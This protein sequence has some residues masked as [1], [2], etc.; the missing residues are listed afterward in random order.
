MPSPRKLRADTRT[1]VPEVS[2]LVRA[3]A[4]AEGESFSLEEAAALL[5][6][7]SDQLVTHIRD[8]RV[9]AWTDHGGHPRLPR[10]QFENNGLLTGIR[11]VLEIFR[12]HDEWRVMRYFL[13]KRQSLNNQRPLDLLRAREVG[14]VIVHAQAHFEDNT[15]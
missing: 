11:Q 1:S 13:S 15:W 2:E 14:K 12:S 3:L 7:S 6:I 8:R 9:V 10:W 4:E 5:K